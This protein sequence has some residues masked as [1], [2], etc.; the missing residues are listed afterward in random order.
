MA[1]PIE[2]SGHPDVA[3]WLLGALDAEE[4]DRFGTHLG[5]CPDCQHTVAEFGTAAQMLKASAGLPTVRL[6]DG[7]EPPSDLQARIL[8][9]VRQTSR[10][11]VRHWHGRY[12][13]WSVAAVAA[14]VV[15]RA[16]IRRPH[17]VRS[18]LATAPATSAAISGSS[19]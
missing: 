2:S 10:R 19:S 9:R 6:A 7:P 18:P 16:L 1:D 13:L 12:S 3:G 4:A 14:G 8:A 11:S 17:G 15:L 5:S